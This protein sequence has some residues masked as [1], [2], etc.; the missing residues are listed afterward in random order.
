MNINKNLLRN[1]IL[2]SFILPLPLLTSIDSNAYAEYDDGIYNDGILTE[3]I[4]DKNTVLKDVIELSNGDIISVGYS[5]ATNL[6]FSPLGRRDA[7]IVKFN[8]NGEKEWIKNYGGNNDDEFFTIN[9]TSDGGFI[10][11]GKTSS[12]NSNIKDSEGKNNVFIKF[13]KNGDLVFKKSF[14][15]EIKDAIEL[16]DGSYVAVG[17]LS[18]SSVVQLNGTCDAVVA[19]YNK[20]DLSQEWI[21]VYGNNNPN[22]LIVQEE[23]ESVAETSDGNIVCVGKY[24]T[25]DIEGGYGDW[26]VPHSIIVSFNANDGSEEWINGLPEDKAS[27]LNSIVSMENGDVI[28]SGAEFANPSGYTDMAYIARYSSDGNVLWK[29]LIGYNTNPN[30]LDKIYNMKPSNDGGVILSMH[31]DEGLYYSYTNRVIK[32]DGTGKEILNKIFDYDYPLSNTAIEL[33]NGDIAIVFCNNLKKSSL[34]IYNTQLSEINDAIKDAETNPTVEKIELA[35]KLVNAMPEGEKKNELQAKINAIIPNITFDKKIHSANL[36]IYIKCE[37]TISLSL[38]T[39]SVTF[40]DFNGTED[41]VK[42]NAVNLT[43]NSSLPYK[44]DA[45]LATEIQNASKNKTMDKEIL[46]LKANGSDEYKSFEDVN[47]T[48]IT[49]IDNQDAGRDNLHGIDIMFKGGIPHQKDIYKTTVRF[50]ASQK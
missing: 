2:T 19:K 9:E 6:E 8:S 15:G 25:E 3:I 40:D 13:D 41:L 21:K 35:R 42:E 33:K 10:V 22:G 18:D 11:T 38:D 49:L 37:N 36:D 23:F 27:Y 7:I 48:P 20:D 50:E 17:N 32:F 1:I 28:V 47:I 39:N 31:T 34:S 26:T 43:V 29:K 14:P 4:G 5:E 24:L 46:N 45:Y 12:D 16:S 44:V 30:G